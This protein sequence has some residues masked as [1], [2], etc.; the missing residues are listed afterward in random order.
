[1]YDA[2]TKQP[3]TGVSIIPIDVNGNGQVDKEERFYS[4]TEELTKAIADGRYPSPPARALHLVSGGAPKNQAAVEFL[5]WILTDGQKY[6][7]EA[8]YINLPQEKLSE[9]LKK[10]DAGK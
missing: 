2:K 9:A 5:R 3:V 6:V 10:L 4:N 7:A 8:G 1:V